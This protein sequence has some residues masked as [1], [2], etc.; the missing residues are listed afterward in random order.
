MVGLPEILAAVVAVLIAAGEIVH[1]RRVARLASLAFGPGRKPLAWT[2]AAPFVRVVAGA[3]VAWGLTVLF[4]IEPK[5]FKAREAEA[6]QQ[7]HVVIVLD[8]SPSMKLDDAGVDGRQRRAKRASDLMDSFFKRVPMELVK[9]SVIATFTSAKPVVIETKDVEV[10]RN[11]LDSEMPLNHAFDSGKTDLF[12]GI[13]E[14][15]RLAHPWERDS[16]TIVILSDGDTVPPS[17]MPQM[18]PSVSE[19]VIVGVGDPRSGKFIAGYQSR[20]QAAEMQ[21]MAVRLHGTYHDGNQYQLPSDL[22]RRMTAVPEP[23]F[24]EKLSL[25]EYALFAVA[26]GSF[27]LAILPWLLHIA[28]ASWKPGF[29]PAFPSSPRRAPVSS[30]RT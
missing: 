14:A 16:T 8:V 25:R 4:S 24:F 7:R 26:T 28:G 29:R 9:L 2:Q 27:A 12:S 17:G 6:N 19:V 21:Q 3:A 11:I 30:V 13:R 18:P 23:G 10:V 20:Q 15:A 22:L 1:R 5:V